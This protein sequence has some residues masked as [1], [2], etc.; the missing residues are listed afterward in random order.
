MTL[1]LLMSR[2]VSL[3]QVLI[4]L[5]S[6]ASF[7]LPAIAQ[8]QEL[9]PIVSPP[10]AVA[11]PSASSQ[12]TPAPP[13]APAPASAAPTPVQL[14]DVLFKN[15]KARAI[16]PAVMGGRVSEIAL[17]PR[18][19]ARL[20]PRT[21]TGGVFKTSDN[22]ISFEPIF[23]KESNLSIGAVAI[24]PSDSDVLWVG[25]GEPSDRNSAGWGN[26]VY[27]ST[28]GGETWQNVGLK[29]SR[30]IGRIAVHPK[31]PNIAYVAASGHLWVDGGERGLF[32]TTD[33]GKTWKLSCSATGQTTPALAAPMSCMDP[34][35]PEILYA[36]FTRGSARRGVSPTACRD[37]RRR[38]RRHLQEHERR[39]NLE[40]IGRRT[41]RANRPDRPRHF[42]EQSQGGDGGG[43]K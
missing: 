16:G 21:G 11:T 39:R 24:A 6:I 32:K 29:E 43:A 20:L 4:S 26:G 19:P 12:I 3:R 42:R 38:C 28:D 37:Q 23:D 14:T 13:S 25:T 27:R 17:D 10:P 40:K 9:A 33:A 7:A 41:S 30:A 2:F 22:G 1:E 8:E 35:N 34:A 36:T 15:L 18:N 31:N 5:C